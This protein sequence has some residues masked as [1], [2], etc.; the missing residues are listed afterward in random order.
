MDCNRSALLRLLACGAKV[1]YFDHHVADEIARHPRLHATVDFSRGVC[2][3]LV[4]DR[5]LGG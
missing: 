4:V 2:T 5:V 1:Q 3:R